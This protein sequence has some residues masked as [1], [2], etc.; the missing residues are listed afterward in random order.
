MSTKVRDKNSQLSEHTFGTHIKMGE[1]TNIMR[2][3]PVFPAWPLL[4][5]CVSVCTGMCM[6]IHICYTH[7]RR[8][9]PHT[10]RLQG[11]LGGERGDAEQGHAAAHS[12]TQ[13]TQLP[14][15]IKKKKNPYKLGQMGCRV[16][17][18]GMFSTEAAGC[19]MPPL[20]DCEA[21]KRPPPFSTLTQDLG[22]W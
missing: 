19:R 17:G 11:K 22:R 2:H 3:F 7:I 14:E 10:A 21:T 4:S 6:S 15:M 20:Q 8:M 1:K 16:A 13:I 18:S 9:Y 12:P 5:A